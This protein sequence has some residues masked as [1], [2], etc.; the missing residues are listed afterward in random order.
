MGKSWWRRADVLAA[1]V[2]LMVVGPLLA[3]AISYAKSRYQIGQCQNNLRAFHGALMAYSNLHEGRLPRVDKDA[4]RNV[5]G[6]VV[7]ILYQEGLGQGL[8]IHC[9]SS[10]SPDMPLHSLE[11][12]DAAYNNREDSFNNL[13]NQLSGDYAYSMGYQALWDYSTACALT[14]LLWITI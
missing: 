9:P 14:P 6:V 11:E 2:L 7:P 8:N 5:A 13:A 3:P 1:A 10:Q 4:P 12:L